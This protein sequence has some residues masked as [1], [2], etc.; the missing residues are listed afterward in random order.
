MKGTR[1]SRPVSHVLLVAFGCALQGCASI[2]GRESHIDANVPARAEFDRFLR[3]DLEAYF[4]A[5]TAQPIAA[6]DYQ[7][8]RDG[9]TQSGLAYPKYYV[10]V[11]VQI[12]GDK[13]QEG[14][15]RLQAMDRER[16]E[17]THFLSRDEIS[18]NPSGFRSVFPE[19]VCVRIEEVLRQ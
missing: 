15:V 5:T 9:P 17:G 1:M 11:V 10:W 6:L 14:A 2:G 12:K 16:F 8:L 3:R 18:S 4:A 19:P 13:G 7:L